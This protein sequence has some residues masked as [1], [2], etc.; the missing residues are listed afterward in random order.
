MFELMLT[1]SDFGLSCLTAMKS[2]TLVQ[3]FRASSSVNAAVNCNIKTYICIISK[4]YVT[5]NINASLSSR[6][7]TKEQKTS[8]LAQ[9]MSM[10]SRQ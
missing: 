3:K 2:G 5:T 10:I 8:T 4:Q 1:S 9:K 6:E 7:Y